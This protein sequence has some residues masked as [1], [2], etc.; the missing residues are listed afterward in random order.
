MGLNFSWGVSTMKRFIDLEYSSGQYLLLFQKICT[1]SPVKRWVG[2]YA[3]KQ[4]NVCRPQQWNFAQKIIIMEE[5]V[6]FIAKLESFISE[7]KYVTE[8]YLS[9][10]IFLQ[11][12]CLCVSRLLRHQSE[13]NL[14]FWTKPKTRKKPS[15]SLTKLRIARNQKAQERLGTQSS[16]LPVVKTQH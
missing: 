13:M 15:Y 5:C 16:E 3:H 12:P 14:C 10:S 1:Y 9:P 7:C 4:E 6:A 8:S 11:G 2:M